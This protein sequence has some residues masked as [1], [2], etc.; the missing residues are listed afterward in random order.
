MFIVI[1]VIVRFGAAPFHMWVPDVYHGA[2]TAVTLLSAAPRS[3]RSRWHRLLV[4]DGMGACAQW[5][6]ML[7]IAVLSMALMA[8][9]RG[10]ADQHQAHA[11]LF[12][13]LACRFLFFL[14]LLAAPTGYSAA[15]FYAIVYALMAA[16]G[17]GVIIHAQPQ[18]FD[19]ENIHDLKGT[20]R[21]QSWLAFMMLL[22]LFSMAGVPP[23]VGFFAK[24]LVLDAV[25]SI[26]RV[27]LAGVRVVFSRS[28]VPSIIPRGQGD[29]L[30]QT[31]RCD[32]AGA[33]DGRIQVNG[34]RSTDAGPMLGFWVVPGGVAGCAGLHSAHERVG[35]SEQGAIY[36]VLN[37]HKI[38]YSSRRNVR[39]G[40]SSLAAR[41][42]HNPKVVGSNPAPLPAP[43]AD[44][45]CSLRWWTGSEIPRS[46]APVRPPPVPSQLADL[47]FAAARVLEQSHRG[48]MIR[49]GL[50]QVLCSSQPSG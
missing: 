34:C 29:V 36:A 26:D 46:P 21:P 12:D 1:G 39:C 33:G 11:G 5:Q 22:I 41:R 23:T 42:A 35:L 49:Q 2:P 10:R 13:D 20:E 14:G 6:D 38:M 8:T 40:W 28:S 15:M 30:R 32:A 16:G 27:W 45:P 43:P 18:R 47:L 37:G 24:L 48:Q 31:D 17:F 3:P 4:D 25:I 9:C 50:E 44:L 19:A 7:M